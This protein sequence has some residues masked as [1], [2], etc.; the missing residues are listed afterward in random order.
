MRLSTLCIAVLVPFNLAVAT[1]PAA[2]PARASFSPDISLILAGEYAHLSND[3]DSYAIPG[4]MLGP[5]TDP[6]PR[7]LSLGESELIISA[8][9]DDLFYGQLTAAVTPENEIELEEAFVQTLALPVGFT[10]RAGRFYS[11]IGYLNPQHPHSLGLRRHRRCRTGRCSPASTATTVCRLSWVAPTDAVRRARRR[12]AARAATSRP[13]ATAT[14]A[15]GRRPRSSHCRRRCRSE[16]CLARSALSYLHAQTLG[17]A[18]VRRHRAGT[19]CIQ[20][21]EPAWRSPT[22][23]GSG[24][25]TGNPNQT[26][27]KLQAEYLWRAED[28][29][30]AADVNDTAAVDRCLQRAAQSG[31]YVQAVYQFVPR[32]R[33]GLRYDQA[34]MPGDAQ[35]RRQQPRCSTP[36]AGRRGARAPMLDWSHSEFSRVRAAVRTAAT[37]R[38]RDTGSEVRLQY[39]M[40]LGRARRACVL[41]L[42]VKNAK[43][44]KNECPVIISGRTV[45][46]V[47]HDA[48]AGG[49]ARCSPASRNGQALAQELGGDAVEAVSATTALQDPHRIEA[50]PSLIAKMRRADLLVCTGAGLEAGWLPQL[51]RAR[52]ATAGCSPASPATSRPPTAVPLLDVPARVDRAEGDVH[53]E[54][55]PHLHLD[56]RNI[57]ARRRRAE[58][59]GW[60]AARPGR[61]PAHYQARAR[62]LHAPLARRRWHAG[63]ARRRRSRACR[64]SITTATGCTCADWLGLTEAGVLEPKPGLP[65]SGGAPG[66]VCSNGSSAAAGARDS[67]LRLRRPSRRINGWPSARGSRQWCCRIPSAPRVRTTCSRCSTPRSRGSR[68]RRDEIVAPR[69]DS[70]A[71]RRCSPG[72]WCSPPTCRSGRRC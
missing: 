22:S 71:G 66:A 68:R 16:S 53:P 64:W 51:V 26:N 17:R 60:R 67:A 55:N 30:F 10:L 27:F 12:V 69:T 25:R 49:T 6:G 31:W 40:S 34:A 8:N 13:A 70:A 28:G 3:P 9:V 72:C 33:A 19:G 32:W 5:E 21:R 58:P 35:R 62:R 43:E 18:P 24:R 50:R 46:W 45:C 54:G 59:R 4:F 52:P 44:S 65:P 2:G 63:N 39:I 29:E 11:G 61:M 41:S 20:R 56:P 36:A 7:G 57:A 47:P 42:N 38:S 48:R 23:C 14:T 37:A 15:R 1:E